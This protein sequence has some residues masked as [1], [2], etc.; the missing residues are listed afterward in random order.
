MPMRYPGGKGKCFQHIINLLPEH[1]TYIETHLGGGAVLRHKAPASKSIGIDIDCRVIE[2]WR[3]HHPTLATFIVGDALKFLCT[4]QYTGCEVVYCDP[5]YLPSTRKRSRVYKHDLT[6]EDHLKLLEVLKALPCRVILS[7]YPSPLYR[8]ELQGWNELQFIAK[9]HDGVRVE[10]LWANYCVPDRLHDAR[11]LG[12]NFRKRQDTKRRR[13][14]LQNRISGLSK[15]E[16]HELATWLLKELT[17][18]G[19]SQCS[20]SRI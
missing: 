16:Q 20:P 6:Q 10:C 1:T 19:G 14:R 7:G 9:A 3:T 12:A 17:D 15:P 18:V 4:Y 2:W 8:H 13:Q 11:F 5:P